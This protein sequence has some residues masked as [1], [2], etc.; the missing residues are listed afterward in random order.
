MRALLRKEIDE[1]FAA[2]AYWLVLIATSLLLA[3][4]YT[5]AV[6]TY[7]EVSTTTAL[8]TLDGIVTPS[9][10]AYDLAIMLLFPFVAIRLV[11]S[12]K[13]SDALKLMLQWPVKMRLHIAAKFVVL[14]FAWMVSLIPFAIAMAIWMTR[15]GHLHA[16]ETLNVLLGYTL[17]FALTSAIAMAAAALMPGA[18][19]AAV[20]VLAFTIG[21]WALD[22]MATGRG[23][24]LQRLAEFTPAA[25]TRTFE[26][27]LLRMDVVLVMLAVTALFLTLTSMSLRRGTQWGG[28]APAA[29]AL[30]IAIALCA[31]VKTSF[32]VSDSQRNSFPPTEVAKLSR[33]AQPLE[34]TIYLAAEDPRMSDFS[35]NVLVKLRRAMREVRVSTPYGARSA[36]FENDDRYGT[37]VY[38][39][40]GKSTVS[41]STTEEIVLE[42][43]YSL[44][45]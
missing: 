30:I 45:R 17:R 40:G 34:I 36:L 32:D 7:R 9:A 38:R 6:N 16:S 4:S 19:N 2:R 41:R 1:L 23:G 12:E 11:A 39:L 14:L 18:A 24:I 8:S 35:N 25:V 31:Q 29:A 5:D 37:I 13:S 33:I 27:G 20:V 44:T 10:G 22:F 43:I 15:G 28:G 26:R 21:T 3:Q 42:T